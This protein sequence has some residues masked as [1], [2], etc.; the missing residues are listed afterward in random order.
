MEADSAILAVQRVLFRHSTLSVTLVLGLSVVALTIQVE[1]HIDRISEDLQ[2]SSSPML[3]VYY[4]PLLPLL[5]AL[6]CS[7]ASDVVA[8]VT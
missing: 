6:Y 3:R 2:V 5:A 4:C 7:T 1:T 8:F